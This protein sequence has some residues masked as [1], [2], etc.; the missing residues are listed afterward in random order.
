MSPLFYAVGGSEVF[1][2]LRE[3]INK[4]LVDVLYCRIYCKIIFIYNQRDVDVIRLEINL[5]E[6]TII[7]LCKPTVEQTFASHLT[8]VGNIA[9][10]T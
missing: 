3:N 4:Q 2:F 7:L 5:T 10:I 8:S 6:R 1:L 9:G